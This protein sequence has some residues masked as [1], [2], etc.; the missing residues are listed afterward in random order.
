MRRPRPLT[1]IANWSR[2]LLTNHRAIANNFLAAT[3]ALECDPLAVG[4]VLFPKVPMPVDQLC[5]L[6]RSKYDTVI[7]P[8]HF[9]GSPDRIRIGIGGETA[10]FTEGLAR[11]QSALKEF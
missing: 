6:L 4:T 2:D 9:F 1:H 8:G 11:I 3:P 7:T 5:Q 10:T